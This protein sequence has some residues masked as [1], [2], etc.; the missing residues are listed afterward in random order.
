MTIFDLV[1]ILCFLATVMVL[2]LAA[3][4]AA[5]GNRGQ[6]L[7]TLRKLGICLAV[8][9]TIVL[10]TALAVPRKVYHLGETQCFD[11]W[12]ITVANV[13]RAAN[14]VEIELRL[15]SR[16][17]R[18]PQG[19]KGTVVYLVDARDYRYN[20]VRDS[21]AVPFDTLL[22]PGESVVAKRRFAVSDKVGALHLIYTHEG[23]F[24]I[25][26]F[27]IGQNTWFHGPPVVSLPVSP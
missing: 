19:E 7:A 26:A 9:M 22:Q 4:T 25:D 11:D 8:Y 18:A 20:P 21:A 24:P 16:A 2:I 13:T 15:S 6:A 10:V 5:R 17:K 23:G 3:I 12:C 1:F 14:S 27:I